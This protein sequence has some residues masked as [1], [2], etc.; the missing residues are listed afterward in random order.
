MKIALVTDSTSDLPA[1][2]IETHNLSMIPAIVIVNGKEYLDGKGLSRDMFYEQ[3]PS[4]T[5]P[6]TTAAPASGKVEALYARLFD[7]GADHII[8][9]HLASQLSGI[10]NAARV[11]AERFAEKITVLDTGQLTMGLG[12]QV[13][14][15]AEA[16]RDGANLTETLTVIQDVRERLRVRAMVDTLEYLRRSGRIS[17]FR[18]AVGA[19]LRMRVFISLQEGLIERVGQVR[20]R[21]K[22]VAQ[23]GEMLRS[24]GPLERLAVLHTNAEEEARQMLHKYAPEHKETAFLCNVTTV[25][26]THVGPRALG[27]AALLP[28]A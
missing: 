6:P 23:F 19:M 11:G 18:A 8:S 2:L 5:T 15:A 10:Y 28:P 24:F 16:L 3:L 9:L 27:F 4:M 20:T 26:G 22:A 12:F 14:A 17:H 25:I 1:E 13:L 21:R 7:E